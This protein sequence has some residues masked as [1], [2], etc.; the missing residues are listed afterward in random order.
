M[1]DKIK[2]LRELTGVG[3]LDAKKVLEA[4]DENIEDAIELLKILSFGNIVK[5]RG[6]KTY[7]D[8]YK[9]LKIEGETN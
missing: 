8:A 2:Q 9:I 3:M 5:Y 4:T 1:S 7:E 6:C